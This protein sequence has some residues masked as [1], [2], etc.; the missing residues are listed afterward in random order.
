[1]KRPV[2]VVAVLTVPVL[3]ASGCATESWTQALFAKQEA[4]VDERFVS[5]ERRANQTTERVS[6]LGN[7]V[8]VLETSMV[9]TGDIARGARDQADV[10]LARA[11]AVEKRV[12]GVGVAIPRFTRDAAA[13]ESMSRE[14]VK[15]KA[16]LGVVHVRF[17]F[18]RADLDE[19]AEKALLAVLKELRENPGLTVALEGA[20]DSMGARDYNLQLSQRRV[21]AVRRFLLAK[22]VDSPRV[23]H[24]A[25]VGPLRDEK[26]PDEQKRRVAVKLMKAE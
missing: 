5:V 18:D 1:M 3:F 24:A 19:G 15:A 14:P 9:Q 10:A 13:R 16:L 6:S 12:A 2:G 25:A 23:I 11:D 17:G 22:G 7:R 20:T 8:T 4:Q 26:I 21:E